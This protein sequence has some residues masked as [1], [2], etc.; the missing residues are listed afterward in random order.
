QK[1]R[2]PKETRVVGVA[3]TPF[4]HE[5]WRTELEASTKKFCGKQFDAASWQSFASSIFYSRGDVDDAASFQA[6][7][8]FLETEVEKS[9]PSSRLYYL[10]TSPTLYEAAIGQLGAADMVEESQGIRR[11]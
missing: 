10:S 7:K 4:T 6:L 2:L 1:G 8:S 5:A 11:I 3:R 9:A